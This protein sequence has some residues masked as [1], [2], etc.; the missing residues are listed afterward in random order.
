[1]KLGVLRC[2]HKFFSSLQLLAL[3]K[4]LIHAWF[5]HTVLL[6]RVGSKAFCL[7]SFPPLTD[8]V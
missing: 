2:L 6:D 5:T 7:V 1:M 3:Y 8:C 4:G